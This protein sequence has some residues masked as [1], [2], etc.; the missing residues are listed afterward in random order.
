MAVATSIAVMQYT[1]TLHPPAGAD[2][3]VVILTHASWGFILVPV[4]A[5]AVILVI[6]GVIK[7]NLS[8]ERAYPKYWW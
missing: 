4:L 7:N 3:I 6:C 8:K 1:R 2:P 5:G